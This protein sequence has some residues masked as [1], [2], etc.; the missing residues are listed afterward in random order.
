MKYKSNIP[1]DVMT[2]VKCIYA[3]IFISLLSFIIV[4][5]FMD[6][7]YYLQEGDFKEISGILFLTFLILLIGIF[8]LFFITVKLKQGSEVTAIVFKIYVAFLVFSTITKLIASFREVS[9]I[10]VILNLLVIGL[11]TTA[12]I[13]LSSK[14]SKQW[15]KKIKYNKL[16]KELAEEEKE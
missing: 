15:F 13:Y 10:I 12:L 6:F 8:I 7:W 3:T 5:S 4:I 14:S 11:L 16:N 9:I 2:A 1:S